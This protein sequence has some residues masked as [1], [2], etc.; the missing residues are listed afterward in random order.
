MENDRAAGHLTAALEES[1]ASLPRKALRWAGAALEATLGSPPDA[2]D[3]D[4]VVRRIDT[5]AEVLRT[6]ADVG[7]PEQLLVQ[8]RADLASMTIAEFVAEWRAPT[9]TE[10]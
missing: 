3:V 1:E 6:H 4:L 9:A 8:V 7:S 10:E 5:G 2:P